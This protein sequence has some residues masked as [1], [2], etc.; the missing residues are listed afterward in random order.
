M[1]SASSAVRFACS[2]TWEARQH[3]RRDVP[4]DR[5]DRGVA[6]LRFGKLGDRMVPQI[7]E[8]FVVGAYAN[9][10][11]N[12]AANG[13]AHGP[14]TKTSNRTWEIRLRHYRGASENVAAVEMRTQLAIERADW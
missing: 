5:H 11:L 10:R 7:V 8:P 2:L 1:T 9:Q 4:C 12:L 14:E 3:L 13:K 6:G